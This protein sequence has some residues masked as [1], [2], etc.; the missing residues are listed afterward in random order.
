MFAFGCFTRKFI[1]LGQ[2]YEVSTWLMN[3]N[4]FRRR[5][6][7]FGSL[8]KLILLNHLAIQTERP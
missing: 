2:T 3:T 1:E 8:S 6:Y 7:A 5:V 4:Y